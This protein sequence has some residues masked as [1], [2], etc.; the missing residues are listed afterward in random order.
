MLIRKYTSQLVE[1]DKNIDQILY[2][3]DGSKL[4]PFTHLTSSLNTQRFDIVFHTY[5]RYR[6]ALMTWLARI[7]TRVG[8]GYRWYSFFFNKKVYA[9]RKTAERHELEYNLA[10]LEMMGIPFTAEDI[11]PRIDVPVQLRDR[12][13]GLVQS[14]G[15]KDG[16]KIVIL[17]PGSGGSA[18]DWNPV[19]FGELALK[20]EQI[21]G[22]RV[23]ITGGRNEDR[24]VGVAKSAAGHAAVMLVGK[25]DLREYAALARMAK[26]FVSNSTGT[27][28][29]AS[30]VGTPVIGLYPQITALSAKRWGP[31]TDKKTIFVPAGRRVDCNICL[32]PKSSPC[33]CMDTITVDSVYTAALKYLD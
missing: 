30:A 27:I 9:H 10:L 26:V 8:T 4:L 22:V 3:D 20:L 24:I 33:E 12:M 31:Y 16:E 21:A 11:T 17:H 14:L 2:Y 7:P 5:P 25:L 28:H 1:D 13:Q 29:I 6:L 23:I 32:S 18:R 15:I 19:H